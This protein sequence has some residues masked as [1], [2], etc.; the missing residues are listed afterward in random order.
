MTP[1][2]SVVMPAYNAERYIEKAIDSI[3]R[4]TYKNFEL[5]I[6]DDYSIDNTGRIIN[7]IRDTR[8]IKIF[9]EY[10]RGISFSTNRAIS[11][12]RGKYIALMDDD[13]ISFE[14]RL[15][16]QVAFM[17]NHES[18]DILGGGAE[19]I[20][21]FDNHLAYLN[22]PKK[23]P[24]Y[25]KAMLLFEGLDFANGTAMIRHNFIKSNNLQYREGYL[26]MQDYQF[27]IE[28]S[29]IGNIS[30]VD[31]L[32]LKYRIHNNNET[33]WQMTN[34]NKKRELLYS[35]MRKDSLISSGFNLTECQYMVVDSV[36]KEKKPCFRNIK[37]ANE[38]YSIFVDILD[39][40]REMKVDYI[41]E[42]CYELKSIYTRILYNSKMFELM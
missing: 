24:K 20:D 17:E 28:S 32:L 29:K 9:N 35:K 13:D 41:D 40:A 15:E 11:L 6:V 18:I 3:L 5:I 25:I 37:E 23:N 36:M 26:G 12:S 39:Q 7:D 14:N 42:I 34:N 21:E 31:D 27:Y 2:V 19:L 38:L 22:S 10:N 4:Q 1:L 33:N 16:I 8:L 30:S